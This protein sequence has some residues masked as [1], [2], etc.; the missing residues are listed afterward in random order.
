MTALQRFEEDVDRAF[1]RE[2][3]AICQRGLDSKQRRKD[4][5]YADEGWEKVKQIEA[6]I[7][8]SCEMLKQMGLLR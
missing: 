2:T 1:T 4:E 5:A 3:R 6:E 7:V 8:E